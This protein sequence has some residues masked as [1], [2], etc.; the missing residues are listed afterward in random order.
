MELLRRRLFQAL[1]A[2][3]I[4][5]A[6]PAAANDFHFSILGDRTGSA[7]PQIYGRTLREIA[8]LGPDFVVNVGDSIQ[9]HDDA[10]IEAQWAEVKSI[11]AR[12]LTQKQYTVAGN[13]D[14][15][16]DR[17]A[18]LYTKHTGFPVHYSFRHQNALFVIL[19][20][21]RTDAPS[22]AEL[23]FLEAE[24]AK[25]RDAAPKFVFIHKPFWAVPLEKGDASFPMHAILRKHGAGHVISGHQHKFIR[26][27]RDGVAYMACGS[28]GGDMHGK[29]L[30]G[31]G[32]AQ[33]CF[34]HHI[35]AR[36]R[37]GEV[38]FAV[39]E[40]D[41]MGGQGRMFAAEDWDGVPKFD[42]GDPAL[43]GRPAT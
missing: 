36:V 12:H 26:R 3:Q 18:A 40:L 11:W 41:G 42:T 21:S 14:I 34:Y 4:A 1:F 37:G 13:H 28:S 32:F 43:S 7:Q 29:L 17:S 9:G 5:P 8:L 20:N 24:L 38:R 10:K 22:A 27:V 23:E 35:W 30:R 16:D 15:W 31:E 19:D 2:P 25:H 6:G 33:G 39:R